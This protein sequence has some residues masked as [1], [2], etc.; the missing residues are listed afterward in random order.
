MLI[1]SMYTLGMGN[2]SLMLKKDYPDHKNNNPC[3]KAASDFMDRNLMTNKD[4]GFTILSQGQELQ[5]ELENER[6]KPKF[7]ELY[8]SNFEKLIEEGK[9]FGDKRTDIA[10]IYDMELGYPYFNYLTIKEAA[11]E[12]YKETKIDIFDVHSIAKK[13]TLDDIRRFTYLY[14]P[15]IRNAIES[16]NDE[17]TK[18]KG[19]R[20][21]VFGAVKNFR[22]KTQEQWKMAVKATKSKVKGVKF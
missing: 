19:K 22:K 14:Q 3:I 2:H 12:L 21:R 15:I 18:K 11:E 17:K 6:N 16:R 20:K 13:C 5:E 7:E 4:Y 10:T 9:K 1:Q 8:G